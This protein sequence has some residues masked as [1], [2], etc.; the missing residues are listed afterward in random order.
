MQIRDRIKELRRVP[1]GELAPNAKNW[2][3]HPEAQREALQGVLDEVG[4]A[5]AVIARELPDGSLVLIDGHLRAEVTGD[6]LVPVLVLDVTEAEADKLLATF[7]PLAAMATADGEKLDALLRDVQ[8]GSEALGSMLEQLM[9]DNDLL[10]KEDKAGRAVSFDAGEA[11]PTYE[12]IITCASESHRHELSERLAAEGL[13]C[14]SA[15][16]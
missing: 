10:P 9:I 3:K 14:R 6:Q 12:L 16:S 1:A 2:R 4:Y 13:V 7:D 11:Q 5:G 15:D 8:T